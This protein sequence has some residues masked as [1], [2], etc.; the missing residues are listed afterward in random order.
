V[1][2]TRDALSTF[3]AGPA[4]GRGAKAVGTESEAAASSTASEEDQ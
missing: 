2:F 3:V 4:R 1:V